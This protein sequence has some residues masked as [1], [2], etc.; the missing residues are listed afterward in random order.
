MVDDKFARH[1]AGIRYS[2]NVGFIPYKP[3]CDAGMRIEPA[4]SPATAMS[5]MPAATKAALPDDE[6]PVE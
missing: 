5:T 3:H 4:W 6:P 2:S 1:G